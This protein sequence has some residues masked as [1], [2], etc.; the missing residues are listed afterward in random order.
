LLA[1][2]PPAFRLITSGFC[3]FVPRERKLHWVR[4]RVRIGAEESGIG[5]LLRCV[6]VIGVEMWYGT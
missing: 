5:L 4:V 1:E 3:V 2:Q 6:I